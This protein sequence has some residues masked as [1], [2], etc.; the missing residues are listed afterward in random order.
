MLT[1]MKL[2]IN[3]A[4]KG[5]PET[6]EERKEQLPTT[7]F[8]AACFFIPYYALLQIPKHGIDSV[9]FQV[10]F[11]AGHF[12]FLGFI[13]SLILSRFKNWDIIMALPSIG[14]FWAS[15]YFLVHPEFKALRPYVWNYAQLCAII[16]AVSLSTLRFNVILFALNIITP[17]IISFYIDRITLGDIIERQAIVY[18]I[19]VLTLYYVFRNAV[20]ARS[21]RNDSAQAELIRKSSELGTWNWNLAS[22][23]V[24]FDARW[25]EILGYEDHELPNVLETWERLIA[26][27][28]LEL[29]REAFTQYLAGQV[30]QYEIK[31]R[32]RHKDGHWVP[33]ISKGKI[34]EYS[35]DGSPRI[36]SGTHFD[37]TTLDSFKWTLRPRN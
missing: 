35:E 36:F 21:L 13:L 23:E 5:S 29:A 9:Q 26:P 25:K 33:I 7:F 34:L 10:D 20:K 2:F 16:F 32:M 18:F 37:F 27:K 24:V 12:V 14:S 4:I 6:F 28:D 8:F 3:E 19:S 17:I 31:F 15:M 30:P 22:N 1:G 11:F